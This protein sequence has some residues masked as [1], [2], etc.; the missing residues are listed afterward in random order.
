MRIWRFVG[1][2]LAV[3]TLVVFAGLVTHDEA[4]SSGASSVGS[5]HCCDPLQQPG[6]PERQYCAE[7]FACCAEGNWACDDNTG[8]VTCTTR[9]ERLCCDPDEE[10]GQGNNPPCFEGAT[11]CATGEWECND[12]GAN[13]TCRLD[14]L[15]CDTCCDPAKE[16]GQG[17]TQPCFEGATCCADGNWQCNDAGANSTC[18]VNGIVCED[19]QVQCC[20]PFEEPGLFGNPI[21]FEGATCC[22]GGNW[23]CND[24]GANS[25]CDLDGFACENCC[26]PR[27]E[28]GSFGNPICFE[29]A[30][31][32]ADGSWQ[33]NDAGAMSTCSADG[34]VCDDCCNPL[35]EPG[36]VEGATCCST[37]EWECNNGAG[38]STC[39]LNGDSCELRCCDADQIPNTSEHPFCETG[40]RCCVDGIWR[41]NDP[42]GLSTC[43]SVGDECPQVCGG[44]AGIPCDNFNEFCKLP[45][46]ECC[47][48]AFGI[49]TEIPEAC[50]EIY[51]PVCG[52]DGLT[53][54]NE[55]FADRAGVSVEHQG[56]C[57]QICGGIAGIPCDDGEYCQLPV[58]QCCCDFQG[59]CV[60]IPEACPQVCDPVCGCDGNT[61]TNACEAGRVSVSIDHVGPCFAG[62]GLIGGVRMES[63]D[64]IAWDPDPQAL[65][66]NLYRYR[67]LEPPPQHAGSC[68]QS[69]IQG[70]S[71]VVP[72]TPLPGGSW[73]LLLA[74][75][76]STG[77]GSLG[78]GWNC[79]ERQP[80]INCEPT[81]QVLC[82]ATGGSW[83]PISCGHYNCGQFPACDAIIPGCDCGPTSNFVPGI[84]CAPDPVCGS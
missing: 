8:A 11:C 53:Y 70:T 36:C 41:C 23:Q 62:N 50:P 54:D 78:I 76:Y 27:E 24:G 35:A 79:H 46:G 39:T 59:I 34:L 21:C 44:I 63:K 19:S 32:C 37:G 58:G 49:C 65:F 77:E 1:L 64:R 25:T 43:S 69:G 4:G 15:A 56:T 72:G 28:P 9:C 48:D 55:C 42:S 13:S 12:A 38:E 73:L 31:C 18:N 20:D 75:Q 3:T 40:F 14:S 81:E 26:N 74:G 2:S 22:A 80:L 66:Y 6:L 71:T 67:M 61:Y 17:G 29:G 16:P 82:E 57:E 51:D 83:D 10:P 47:C 30:T 45:E 60:E 68:Y 52:C 84:G 33:C 5:A 7:G